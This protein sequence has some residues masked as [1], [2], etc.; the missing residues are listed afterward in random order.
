MDVEVTG[1]LT[2]PLRIGFPQR[3]APITSGRPTFTE[4]SWTSKGQGLSRA[5]SITKRPP[6]NS[7]RFRSTAGRY[8]PEIGLGPLP[9]NQLPRR[10]CSEQRHG[11]ADDHGHPEA[12]DERRIDRIVD[13]HRGFWICSLRW[14]RGRQIGSLRIDRL[15]RRRRKGRYGIELVG[16]LS[17][18]DRGHDDAE[19]GNR[20]QAGGAGD[21]SE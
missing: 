17:V 9:F 18:E 21:G 11:R 1:C 6:P 16:Q 5:F 4:T 10:C 15:P 8:E 14:T 12:G 13:R 19:D 3:V 2:I 7:P 20:D